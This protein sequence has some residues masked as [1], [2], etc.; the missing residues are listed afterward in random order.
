MLNE[1][2]SFLLTSSIITLIVVLGIQGCVE[3]TPPQA[4]DGNNLINRKAPEIS[5]EL[6]TGKQFNLTEANEDK[7]IIVNFFGTWCPPCRA[8]LPALDQLYHDN[9]SSVLLLGIALNIKDSAVNRFMRN[10]KLDFPV[11]LSGRNKESGIPERYNVPTVP[12]TVVIGKDGR[13]IYYKPGM[14]KKRHFR[15]LNKLIQET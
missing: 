13:I 15:Y 4:P 3:R 11:I 5:S 7:M 2:S 14:L 9:D 6:L 12:T 8:E 1:K 10:V